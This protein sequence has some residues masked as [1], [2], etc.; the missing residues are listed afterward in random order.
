MTP[1]PRVVPLLVTVLIQ[2]AVALLATVGFTA[3]GVKSPLSTSPTAFGAW[4]GL[5]FGMVSLLSAW[6]V[7]GAGHAVLRMAATFVLGVLLWGVTFGAM[8]LVDRFPDAAAPGIA[9]FAQFVVVQLPLWFARAARGRHR[10]A[11]SPSWSRSFSARDHQFGIRHLLGWMTVIG[12]LSGVARS[13]AGTAG[14]L[15]ELVP[16]GIFMIGNSLLAWPWLAAA[17]A[18]RQRVLT[19]LLAAVVTTTLCYVEPWAFRT[20]SRGAVPSEFFWWSNWVQSVWIFGSVR[21]LDAWMAAKYT[22]APDEDRETSLTNA[23]TE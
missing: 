4:F 17:L 1:S 23:E 2:L 16:F 19:I 12:I 18:S 3:S 14:N 22:T 6:A 20:V 21:A 10:G 15:R 8:D 9:M 5:L 13:L 7:L 11:A